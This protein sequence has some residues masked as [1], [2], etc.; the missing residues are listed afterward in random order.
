MFF[1]SEGKRLFTE[2]QFNIEY[3]MKYI[4][5]DCFTLHKVGI[6]ELEPRNNLN[7]NTNFNAN[8]NV[9]ELSVIEI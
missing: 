4:N 1:R 9:N 7:A 8:T 6:M 3:H 5:F 2:N